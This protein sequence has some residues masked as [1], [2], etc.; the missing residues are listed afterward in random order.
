MSHLRTDKAIIKNLSKNNSGHQ[1]LTSNS[2]KMKNFSKSIN[3]N[4]LLAIALFAAFVFLTEKGH[5][6]QRSSDAGANNI[7]NSINSNQ[8]SKTEI[9]KNVIRIQNNEGA[10]GIVKVYS[11]SGKKI[12]ESILQSGINKIDASLLPNGTYIICVTMDGG[13]T[14]NQKFIKE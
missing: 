4:F 5:A 11:Q 1:F 8:P 6:Q 13:A 3:K 9:E 2:L 10:Y 12:S 7:N 14:Y